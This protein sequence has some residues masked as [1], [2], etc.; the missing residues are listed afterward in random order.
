MEQLK[1][2]NISTDSLQ[3]DIG[4]YNMMFYNL[5]YLPNEVSL[6]Q[7]TR[8][9]TRTL[10][11]N[12]ERNTKKKNSP[13]PGFYQLT[14]WIGWVELWKKNKKIWIIK[15]VAEAM[16]VNNVNV[17]QETNLL[18]VCD[19]CVQYCRYLSHKWL[20]KGCR[21]FIHCFFFKV[22]IY[23]WHMLPFKM[24]VDSIVCD[25]YLFNCWLLLIKFEEE[26]ARYYFFRLWPFA[27]VFFLN[28]KD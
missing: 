15:I 8:F 18:I 13:P 3:G 4:I 17:R 27:N 5:N 26:V 23:F 1:K 10:P 16:Q 22:E 20:R 7:F 6:K 9:L 14:S 2:F 12:S 21:K 25:A 24:N 19:L 11:R 28:Y